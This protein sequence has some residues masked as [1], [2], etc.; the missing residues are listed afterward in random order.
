[1]ITISTE[2]GDSSYPIEVDAKA[3]GQRFCSRESPARTTVS[4]FVYRNHS[5]LL[6][7]P[8]FSDK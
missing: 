7:Q 4:L 8:R 1:M 3:I 6:F 5:G 2:N